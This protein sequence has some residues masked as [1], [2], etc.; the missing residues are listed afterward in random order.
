[1]FTFMDW[2]AYQRGRYGCSSPSTKVL[3]ALCLFVSLSEEET[4]CYDKKMV[5]VEVVEAVEVIPDSGI[6][7]E[8]LVFLRS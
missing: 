4:L 7:R 6:L 2:V 1:M 5:S 3:N 8:G